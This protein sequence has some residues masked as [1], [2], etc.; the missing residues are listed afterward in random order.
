MVGYPTTPTDASIKITELHSNDSGVYRCEVM[1]GIEDGH[2][3][4]DVQVQGTF[5]VKILKENITLFCFVLSE[6]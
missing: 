1:N 3:I 6:I 5:C 2:D 4:V